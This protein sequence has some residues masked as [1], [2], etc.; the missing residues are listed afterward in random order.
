M[1]IERALKSDVLKISEL[2]YDLFNVHT[3]L[4]PYYAHNEDSLKVTIET[5]SKWIEMNE[6]SFYVAKEEG[7]IVGFIIG[8]IEKEEPIYIRKRKGIV[9]ALFVDSKFGGRGI[10]KELFT[11]LSAWFKENGV[12]DIELYVHTKNEAA[13]GA[14]SKY[15]FVVDSHRMRKRI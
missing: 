11:N 5:Y 6:F 7:E 9:I 3:Q 14:W 2:A 4:D 12:D 1:V 8:K 13:M 15:G 10:S